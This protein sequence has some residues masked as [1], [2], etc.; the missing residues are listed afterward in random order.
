MR[1]RRRDGGKF[2]ATTALS[3]VVAAAAGLF[4]TPVAAQSLF[5]WLFGERPRAQVW[6]ETGPREPLRPRARKANEHHNWTIA[7]Y[8][9]DD[10]LARR[11]DLDR[12]HRKLDPLDPAKSEFP[13]SPSNPESA[14]RIEPVKQRLPLFMV[15]SIADQHVSVYNHQGLVARSA[16][17]TGMAGHPT[18]RGIYTIIGRERFHASNLYSGA[19]MPYMQRVTWSGVAMHVGVVPGHPA[20]H[21]CI[22]LPA[23]F[24]VKLWGLTKIGERVVISPQEATPREFAHASLPAPKMRI[25]EAAG[26]AASVP[27]GEP[28]AAEPIRLNPLQ[29]AEKLKL[30]AVADKAAALKTIRESAALAA[31]KQA[32][33]SRLQRELDAAE[34]ARARARA[35]L[36]DATKSAAAASAAVVV[37]RKES[38]VAAS[39]L[40]APDAAT[41]ADA[42]TTALRLVQA[43]E[44]A[45]AAKDAA[46]TVELEAEAALW[47]AEA[48]VEAVQKA[49]LA[50]DAE[51]MEAGKRSSDARAALDVATD[52]ERE[53]QRRL[54]PVS[55]LVSKKDARIYVRQGLAPLFDAPVKLRDPE[56]PLG[57]HL[58]IASAASEDGTGLK[59]TVLSWPAHAG[60]EPRTASKRLAS[61]EE[62]TLASASALGGD[63]ASASE[64]LDR[65]EIPQDVRDRI[66]E[67]LWIGGSLI[68]SDQ[69]P[70]SET[71]NV[72]TDLTVKLR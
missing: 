20:S 67:L 12:S 37:A 42:K 4:A 64:A 38:V 50:N 10:A 41:D 39:G 62:L 19:P 33:A 49:S 57:S 1:L 2:F 72:G 60:D 3:T 30:K 51:L 61:A 18:P 71:G 26:K 43:Y 9:S 16:V 65:I 28:V 6:R 68:V 44:Q 66:G 29:Y 54:A 7:S 32:E 63:A 31:R 47:A 23:G 36:E 59:W 40:R 22:R 24:A 27:Q 70:S 17:S 8:R 13:Q 48:K 15:V 35:K 58:F 45:F 5:G 14:R 69:P 52:A 53:A 46:A 55:L 56:R 21:G 25:E 11:M 34:A